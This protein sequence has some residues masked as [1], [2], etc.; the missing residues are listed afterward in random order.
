MLKLRVEA[1]DDDAHWAIVNFPA[2]IDAR[3]DAM[4]PRCD[5]KDGSQWERRKKWETKHSDV[6]N[7][8]IFYVYDDG[9]MMSKSLCL[10]QRRRRELAAITSFDFSASFVSS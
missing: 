8:F 5:V 10:Q 7:N 3:T 4:R 6:L 2:S 9:G 1:H